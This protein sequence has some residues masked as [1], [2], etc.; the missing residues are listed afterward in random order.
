MIDKENITSPQARIEFQEVSANAS[1]FLHE[2]NDPTL[3]R[4]RDIPSAVKLELRRHQISRLSATISVLAAKREEFNRRMEEYVSNLGRLVATLEKSLETDKVQPES[5]APTKHP[6]LT[7]VCCLHCET[8]RRFEGLKVVCARE[9][10]ESLT[11]P[12]ELYVLDR[13]SLKKGHFRC[14]KCGTESLV[15]KAN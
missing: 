4:N 15:I 14:L 5:G 12:T 9:S 11:Q 3:L 2:L 1:D 13:G 10:E 7:R 8:E 6:T